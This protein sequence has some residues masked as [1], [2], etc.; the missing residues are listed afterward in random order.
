[1]FMSYI[2]TDLYIVESIFWCSHKLLLTT[3]SCC[4][5]FGV[6]I[7]GNYFFSHSLIP[8]IQLDKG[9]NMLNQVCRKTSTL[10]DI[11]Y[12]GMKLYQRLLRLTVLSCLFKKNWVLSCR[13]FISMHRLLPVLVKGKLSCR[14]GE[15]AP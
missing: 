7:M 8:L 14:R 15:I 6:E 12:P 13:V 10:A 4:T 11:T 9:F 2:H 1:M 3:L 5:T